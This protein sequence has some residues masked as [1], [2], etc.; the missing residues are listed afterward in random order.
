MMIGTMTDDASF[1]KTHR[2]GRFWGPW[3]YKHAATYF[4]LGKQEE[5]IPLRDYYHRHTRSL[6]WEMSDIIPFGNNILFRL[7]FGWL[8]PPKVSFLKLTTPTKLHELHE[9]KHIVEDYLVPIS[10]LKETLAV[11]DDLVTFYPLWLCPC[12]IPSTKLTGLV[13]PIDPNDDMYVDVGIYGTPEKCKDPLLEWDHIQVHKKAE[14]FLRKIGG[15][16]ALYAQTYQNREEFQE[17]FNHKLYNEVRNKYNCVDA[18]PV[19]YDKVS[20]DARK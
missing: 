20:R 19:V 12:R 2:I 14:E 16:Q 4:E 9:K 5:F 10:R 18:L 3:F 13:N 11:V 15:F 8:V 7:L 17:M 1:W 6:F